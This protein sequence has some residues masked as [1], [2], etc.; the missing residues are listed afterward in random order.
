MYRPTNISIVRPSMVSADDKMPSYICLDCHLLF[1]HSYR[2]MQMCKRAETALRQYPLTGTLP[3]PMEKP[4]PPSKNPTVVAA[5]VRK[6]GKAAD[7]QP[8]KLLNT[9]A[10]SKTVIIEDVQVLETSLLAKKLATASTRSKSY[11]MKVENNQELSMDDIQNMMDDMDNEVEEE[12]A[13]TAA[14]AAAAAA[15]SVAAATS[16]PAAVPPVQQKLPIKP[17]V[18]NKPTV[19]ILNKGAAVAVEPELAT[20]QIKRGRDGNVAIVT[21]IIGPNTVPQHEDATKDA[22]IV[23]TNVFPCPDC[24]RSFPLLQLLEIH[25]LNHTR[26]RSFQCADCSKAFFSKYDLQKHRF[27]HTG[28]KPFACSVCDKAF[29]RRALLHRHESTH[30]DL[31]KFI[32][33]H[34][35]KPFLSREDMTKH[36]ERHTKSRPFR[37]TMCSKSFAFKQGL[38]RHEVV[39]SV[40]LPFPCEHCPRSF[41]TSSKLARHLVAHAGKRAY[42]CKYCSKSYILSHHLSRH[43]RMH[44]QDSGASFACSICKESHQSYDSLIE[45]SVQHANMSLKCP[46]C[47]EKIHDIAAVEGHMT[48]H[49]E[50]ERFACEFC[51]LIFLSSERLQ[52]HIEDEHVLDMDM[53]QND[54]DRFSNQSDA[55]AEFDAHEAEMDEAEQKFLLQELLRDEQ[56]ASPPPPVKKRKVEATDAFVI[57]KRTRQTHLADVAPAET[58][59]TTR[60]QAVATRKGSRRSLIKNGNS[61]T[62]SRH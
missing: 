44:K 41:V 42:P 59:P 22:A 23:A 46:L 26:A 17:K 15:S 34:C 11:Q 16:P 33:V 47:N 56:P 10:N 6:D 13:E 21:E 60:Q 12:A 37:C 45:H 36:A 30:T 55:E 28:E 53:Y 9:L 29:T 57:P 48:T 58:S 27:I 5:V 35:E 19:R 54:G 49:K 18:L 52:K 39:H 24:E 3:A 62:N 8:R 32:C 50:G 38:E 61:A 51:D 7:A 14:A 4:R 1:E 20:K 43:L 40:N 2:F 25:R 31:P